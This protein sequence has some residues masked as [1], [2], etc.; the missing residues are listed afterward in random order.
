MTFNLN[1]V[2][3]HNFFHASN[4]LLAEWPSTELL[5]TELGSKSPG[6]CVI[7][8]IT[9]VSYGKLYVNMCL[10]YIN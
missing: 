8:H 4:V 3:A 7:K 6:A 10:Y 5:S 2:S 9:A 1:W